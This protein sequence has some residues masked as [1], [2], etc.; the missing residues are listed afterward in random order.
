MRSERQREASQYRAEGSEQSQEIRAKADRDVTVL[1]ADA[2]RQADILHGEGDAEATRI[3]AD[4]F[5]RDPEFYGYYRTL[6]AYK[7]S[8]GGEDTQ[9]V[10]SPSSDFLR[11]LS[12]PDA[13]KVPT[14]K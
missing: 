7:R 4:A 12:H 11:Y 1:L 8:L 10:L 2:R 5:G 9:F 14:A 6:D 13:P 3:Y